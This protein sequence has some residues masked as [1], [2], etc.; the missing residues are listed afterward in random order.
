MLVTVLRV[1]CYVVGGIRC[2]NFMV[3]RKGTFKWKRMMKY[4]NITYIFKASL[5][6]F[7]YAL[8]LLCIS[9]IYFFFFEVHEFIFKSF[10]F[11]IFL[12]KD[13]MIV[14]LL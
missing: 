3:L 12:G 8:L 4:E 1:M 7:R 5:K 2:V 6:I 11:C 13:Y 14:C 10:M 9:F